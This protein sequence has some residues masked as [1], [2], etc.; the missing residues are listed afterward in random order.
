[1]KR[2][3]L[4]A[5]LLLVLWPC[6][7]LRAAQRFGRPV[8][9]LEEPKNYQFFKLDDVNFPFLASTNYD[10]SCLVYRGTQYYYVEIA[11]HSRASSPVTISDDFVEFLK[12]GYTVLRTDAHIAEAQLANAAG[13]H[14]IPTPPP[15][16]PPRSITT[17]TINANATTSGS[18]TQINGT[19]TSTTRDTSGQAGANFGNALGNVIAARRFYRAQRENVSLAGYLNAFGWS[20]TPLTL[21]PGQTQ[22]VIMTFQ[23]FKLK[24]AHFQV[25]IH[26]G[27]DSFPFKYKE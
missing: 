6:T 27:A 21:Q 15:Q 20:N 9:A 13:E 3:A 10:V 12:P 4:F 8:I 1:M 17:T 18:M 26:V 14:F 5:V 16:L 22:K 7:S 25:I 24:K 2:W 11:I 19:A 23:Q